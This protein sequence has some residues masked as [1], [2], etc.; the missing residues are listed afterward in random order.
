VAV[1][2]S[3]E[4][5][6]GDCDIIADFTSPAASM[7]NIALCAA[8]GVPSVVGTT[9]FSEQQMESVES[10]SGSIPLLISPNMSKGINL[11]LEKIGGIVSGLPG[12]DIEIV[13]KHHRRKKDAP[14]G[15]ALRIAGRI[16]RAGKKLHPVFGRSGA[17]DKNEIGVHA[18]RG[19]DIVGEHTVILA[20]EGETIEI[21]HRAISRKAFAAGTLSAIKYLVGRPPGLY[22]MEDLLRE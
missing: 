18:V 13:E 8:R 9:G 7:E 3:L 19:G 21:T 15:T 12:F 22:S 10:F 4:E 5:V 16:S 20:G 1:N 17:R 6:L 14:S 11:L 2:S